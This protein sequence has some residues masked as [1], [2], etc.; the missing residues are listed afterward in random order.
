MFYN[1]K[2]F[3]IDILLINTGGISMKF[4][5][6]WIIFIISLFTVVPTKLYSSI[7]QN[8]FDKSIIFFFIVSL[9]FIAF[10]IS[11]IMCKDKILSF[12]S[13]KNP[14]I[15]VTSLILSSSFFFNAV[16]YIIYESNS[17]SF[18]QSLAMF[19]L[20][21][22]SGITFILISLNYFLGKNMFTKAQ[23]MIFSPVLW[24]I[25][26]TISFLSI[27]DDT[28][29]QYNVALNSFMLLFFLYHTQVFVTSI[30]R[31]IVKRLFAF[32]LPAITCSIIYCIPQIIY[33][34]KN[35]ETLASVSF[36]ILITQFIIGI[37]ICFFMISIQSQFISNNTQD[38]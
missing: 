21:I 25:A 29:D 34:L 30:D 23:F 5:I 4:R 8:G 9:V 1:I 20:S 26:N 18:F 13:Y 35:V 3:F 10:L 12:K 17:R 32:G 27:S 38:T 33:H 11:T 6:P 37:Y 31:N 28:P 22:L 14:Y 2:I 7:I 19:I 24:F 16:S 15:G 36:S